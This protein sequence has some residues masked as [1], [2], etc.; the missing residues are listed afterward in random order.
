MFKKIDKP[1]FYKILLAIIFGIAAFLRFFRLADLLGFWYDQGRDALVIWDFIYKGKLFLIGPTTGIEGIF[2]G[3]WYYWLITPA[4]YL[5]NGNPVWPAAFLVIISIFSVYMV[6]K[7]GREM[8]GMKMSLLATFIAATSLYIVSSSRWLSNPTPMFLIG[9][10]LIWAVFRFLDKKRWA[11]PLMA[12]LVGMALNFGSAMEVFYIPA[13]IILFIWKRKL[14]PDIKTILVSLFIFLLSFAPQ[15]I[16]EMRHPG[17]LSGA[18]TQFLFQEKSFS[19][20]FWEMISSRLPFYYS[21]F[22]SKFWINGGNIFAPFLILAVLYLLA[23]KKEI[24]KNEKFIVVSAFTATPFLGGLFFS[25]NNG[26]LYDYYFTGYY[27]VFILLFS[28]LL[29]KISQGKI[30]KIIVILFLGIFIFKNATEYKKAYLLNIDDYKTIVLNRQMAAIDWIYKNADGREFNVDE[31]VPPVIPY[32]YQYL[33]QWLGTVKYNTQPL[34]KNVDLLYT[35]YEVDT[36]HPE[37]LQAWLDRQK[38]IGVVLKEESF[39]GITVQERQRI[40]K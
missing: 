30:G 19:L 18:F 9:I 8:G 15:I 5:G 6:A 12:F 11:F 21:V 38:G 31:Y 35:L 13:L 10:S 33:F 25:G 7:V 39:G 17:V 23:K 34:T 16:F 27:F 40:N 36:N 14:L 3:P 2:R 20:S 32:A 22:S 1:A 26:N 37:R 29:T 4:Y 28:Y 24:F